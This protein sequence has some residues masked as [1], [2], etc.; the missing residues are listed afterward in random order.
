MKNYLLTII[1]FAFV[2]AFFARAQTN[3]TGFVAIF[4][5]QSLAGWHVSAKTGRNAAGCQ[6]QWTF[7]RQDADQKLGRH[8][9]T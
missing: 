4:D 2:V 6:I 9:V 1:Y 3:E 8:Y 5:G 7:T